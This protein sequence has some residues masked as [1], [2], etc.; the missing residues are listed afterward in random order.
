VQEPLHRRFRSLSNSL[1]P[2]P[3]NR[4]PT[5]RTLEGKVRGEEDGNDVEILQISHVL[6]FL[7]YHLNTMRC[8][9][10]ANITPGAAEQNNDKGKQRKK[11]LT[12][13]PPHIPPPSLTALTIASRRNSACSREGYYFL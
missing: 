10:S 8:E 1:A 3:V 5:E 2:A 11:L 4:K 9:S 13:A 6:P 12:D 7:H